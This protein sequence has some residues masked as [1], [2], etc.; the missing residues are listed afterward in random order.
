VNAGIG[1]SLNLEGKAELD[2]S[3]SFV[4][5]ESQRFTAVSCLEGKKG[6]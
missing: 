2:A 5:A 6:S 3:I 4:N 1:G